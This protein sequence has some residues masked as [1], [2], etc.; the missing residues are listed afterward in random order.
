M[1]FGIRILLGQS[2]RNLDQSS[3]LS[4][5]H[6]AAETSILTPSVTDQGRVDRSHVN[7][8]FTIADVVGC[9][10]RLRADEIKSFEMVFAPEQ[11]LSADEQQHID[12][13]Y[14]W[15]TPDAVPFQYVDTIS[16][17]KDYNDVNNIPSI[18]IADL[19]NIASIRYPDFNFSEDSIPTEVVE[20]AINAICSDA[21]TP[22]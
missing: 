14:Q 17:D 4:S 12:A 18:S 13:E 16:F 1:T 8:T 5:I 21:I 22:Y 2:S 19:R 20:L 15:F 11:R 7:P 10:C 3:P 6:D 9:F